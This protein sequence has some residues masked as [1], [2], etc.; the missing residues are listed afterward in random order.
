MNGT[1]CIGE[2]VGDWVGRDVTWRAFKKMD[3]SKMQKLIG[4]EDK[5]LDQLYFRIQS[6][7]RHAADII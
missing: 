1:Y 3:L 4:F 7:V 6:L 2:I 5:N